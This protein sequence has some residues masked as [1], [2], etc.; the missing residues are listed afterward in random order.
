MQRYFSKELYD[1]KFS[2]SKDDLYHIKTVMRMNPNDLVEVVYEN[3]LYICHLDDSYDAII[4]KKIEGERNK[5]V[6]CTLCLPLLTEQKFSFVLQKATELGIDEIIPVITE[7]SIVNLKDKE[8]KKLNRWNRICKE[9]AEQ[10]KRLDIPKISEVKKISELNL[11]GLK[12][13]C[14]TK[15]KSKSIKNVLQNTT[16]CDRM[17]IMVGPEGGISNNEEEKLISLGFIPV[18]LGSNIM[19]VETVPIFM[20]SVLNYEMME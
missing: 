8:D 9:A 7:R 5:K 11:E 19:R 14:S 4:D 15:E 1:N 3:N 16:N 2:L 18:T 17:V 10:S 20:L 12:I 13:V 6:Y